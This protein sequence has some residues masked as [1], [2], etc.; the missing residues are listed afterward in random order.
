MSTFL[1]FNPSSGSA[2]A[3]AKKGRTERRATRGVVK[4]IVPSAF[5]FVV[6]VVRGGP[7]RMVIDA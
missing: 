3:E 5:H 1:M 2:V 7:S 6:F 4:S